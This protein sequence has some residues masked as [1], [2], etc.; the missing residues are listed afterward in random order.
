V[1]GGVISVQGEKYVVADAEVNGVN[2]GF[3][4]LNI[5]RDSASRMPDDPP[6]IEYVGSL[7]GSSSSME[8]VVLAELNGGTILQCRND[9]ISCHELM[10]VEN[11]ELKLLPFATTSR[12]SYDPPV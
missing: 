1:K 2:T 7:A 10:I 4:V 9:E 6:T 8:E 5:T 3:I 11:G 12:N